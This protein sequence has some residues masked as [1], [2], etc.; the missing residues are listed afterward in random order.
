MR[1]V[2]AVVSARGSSYLILCDLEKSTAARLGAA[3]VF[4]TRQ[5]RS[6]FAVAVT[7]KSPIEIRVVRSSSFDSGSEQSLRGNCQSG[8]LSGRTDIVDAGVRARSCWIDRSNLRWLSVVAAKRLGSPSLVA[9]LPSS[10]GSSQ[11]IATPRPCRGSR[12][13]VSEK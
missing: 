13:R 8:A 12:G 6:A 3:F 4:V 5:N 11:H 10:S 1:S 9:A 2:T 7:V